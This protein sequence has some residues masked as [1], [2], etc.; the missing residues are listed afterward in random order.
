MQ[1]FNSKMIIEALQG[2]DK[3]IPKK[4]VYPVC[5]FLKIDSRGFTATDLE[6][7][8][9]RPFPGL[10]ECLVPFREFMDAMNA[11][12]GLCEIQVQD[13]IIQDES[14]IPEIEVD[15]E[16]NEVKPHIPQTMIITGNG[17]TFKIPVS[18]TDDYPETQTFEPEYKTVIPDLSRF[19]PF[20]SK[21]E[22]KPAMNGVYIGSDITGTDA[23][24]L[25]TCKNPVFNPENPS[26]IIHTNVAKWIKQDTTIEY[27]S[28]KGC[29]YLPLRGKLYF[30]LIRDKYPEFKNVIPQN[31]PYTVYM[32]RDALIKTLNEAMKSANKTAHQV[33]F[34]FD[35]NFRELKIRAFDVDYDKEYS[36]S[37]PCK[38]KDN[39]TPDANFEYGMNA[40]LFIESLK[41]ISDKVIGIQF[42]D[43]N[44]AMT[45]EPS[46]GDIILNMPVMLNHYA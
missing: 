46:N 2:F 33:I 4:H 8:I 22:L 11:I 19:I 10:P 35:S 31:Q 24:R 14:Y 34:G 5:E 43:A 6:T 21:D 28:E 30:N 9:Y 40:K 42:K 1:K 17:K 38:F 18:N 26:I 41:T 29:L 13:A 39:Q 15:S 36:S 25:I 27:D 45:I 37:I 32:L 20:T 7:T 44:R 3:V 23:H 12:Q 16:G